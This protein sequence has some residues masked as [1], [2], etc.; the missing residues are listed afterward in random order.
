MIRN[1]WTDIADMLF[2]A[3]VGIC[4]GLIISFTGIAVVEFVRMFF[5]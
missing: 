4:L 2:F 5:L 1:K 3:F